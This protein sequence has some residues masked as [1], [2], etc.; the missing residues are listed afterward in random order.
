MTIP[1]A[2]EGEPF[3]DFLARA[4]RLNEIGMA[5]NFVNSQPKRG[6]NQGPLTFP[7]EPAQP[8]E[9]ANNSG[10]VIN[11]L[12]VVGLDV[13][14]LTGKS[15]FLNERTIKAAKP[16]FATHFGRA[17]VAED[18]IAKGLIG[19]VY[20]DGLFPVKVKAH[21]DSVVT[22][23]DVAGDASTMDYMQ[24]CECGAWEII[25]H[26]TWKDGEAVWATV[27][28][29]G[30]DFSGTLVKA[31]TDIPES[32]AVEITGRESS[33]GALLIGKPSADNLTNV[34]VTDRFPLASGQYTMLK[35][36]WPKPCAVTDDPEAGGTL[37]TAEGEWTLTPGNSGFTCACA[38]DS[39]SAAVMMAGG[40]LY[41]PMYVR[42]TSKVSD[43]V[44]K[45]QLAT[46]DGSAQ[47]VEIECYR[48]GGYAT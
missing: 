20:I 34:L 9:V 15:G 25:D 48:G 30:A 5:T 18:Q 43:S 7:R 14:M 27:R 4:S 28:Y 38:I 47:S 26:Q 37:G 40:G 13:D 46:Y 36:T 44:V 10:E 17:G 29:V 16:V 22:R 32:S 3:F 2:K 33:T 23:C 31:S 45:V 42:V 6:V 24:E 19:R 41:Y 11:A 1:I 39:E 21:Q 12:Q 8:L 35:A